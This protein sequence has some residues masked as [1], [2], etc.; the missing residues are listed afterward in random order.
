MPSTQPRPLPNAADKATLKAIAARVISTCPSLNDAARLVANEL[1]RKYAI[2]NHDPDHVYFHRFRSAQSSATSFTGWQHMSETPYESLTLTQLVIHRFRATDVDNADLLDLY[3]GFYS[4]G[5]DAGDFNETNEVR[6]HGHQ[7]LKDFWAIDFSERYRQQLQAFWNECAEDFRTLAKC[8][9]LVQ[10]IEARENRQLSEHDLQTLLD[11]VIGPLTWPVSLPTLRADSAVGAG[12]T[13]RALDIAGHA[14][15]NVLCISAAGGRQI[16]YLPGEADAFVVCASAAELHWWVLQHM[17]R[18]GQRRRLLEHFPLAERQAITAGLSNLMNR[19]VSTWGQSDH[20]LINQHPQMI[21]GDAFAWLRDSTRSA[22]FAEADLS[23]TANSDLRKKLWIGYLSAGLKVFG[24]MAVVGW[25]VALPV[26]GASLANMGLNI[27][28]AVSGRTAAERK[29][30]VIGAILSG[31]DMLF[32]LPFLRGVGSMAE[33]SAEAEAAEWA[34]YADATRTPEESA[35]VVDEPEGTL[36]PPAEHLP[37][38]VDAAPP[39]AIAQ[40]YQ[41][42]EVLDGLTPISAEGKFQGI[43]RLDSEPPYAILLD[44]QAYYVRYFVDSRGGGFWAIVD[45]ARPNQFVHALPVRLNA[46]G[47]WERISRLGLKAGGQC[48]GTQCAPDLELDTFAPEHAEPPPPPAP[49]PAPAPAEQPQLSTARAIGLVQTPYDVEPV[50][51]ALLKNWA[52]RL[53]ETHLHF[54]IGPL[55]DLIAPDR[56]FVHFGAKC[57]ALV[58]SA[59]RFYRNLRWDTLPPRPGIPTVDAATTIDEFIIDA[60]DLAPGLVI[61]QTPGRITS[62]RLMIEHMATFARGGVRTL[63]VNR[64]LND[65]AQL[66][67]NQYFRTGSLSRD[68]ERYLTRMGTDPLERFNELEL[69]KA[70]RHHGIRVQ[71][72]DCAAFYRRPAAMPRPEQQAVT[73]HLTSDIMLLDRSLNDPG[74]WVVL[75]ETPNTNT[76][77]GFAGLSELEGGIGLRVTEVDP[78]QGERLSLDP[79]IVIPRGPLAN[80]GQMSG[81]LETFYADLRLQMEAAPVVRNPQQMSR[82]L[83]RSGMFAFEHS[84]QGYALLH[85]SQAEQ[86]VRTAVQRLGSGYFFIERPA[87]QRV[88]LKAYATLELL[89]QALSQE[90]G[91]MLQS[92]IHD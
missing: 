74:K 61:A 59:K 57:R 66:D 49:E 78:G 23:L 12:Y 35:Y 6:L 91:L 88:H 60:L 71:A 92:R 70:A 8:N 32:D 22:M 10:A 20:Q 2:G 65:F 14:T 15:S 27:D 45:P 25:P 16:L 50:N 90:Y 62:M 58:N 54:E 34:Q 18:P 9:F 86:I 75:T 3:G 26:I 19:L 81:V 29:E 38:P 40:T 36:P 72:T 55:G 85:R 51:R 41:C 48:L 43:Y 28:Q 47:A 46:E 11:A 64:L 56:H 37:V 87:W 31:I 89:A 84:E 53:P 67:L 1:L 69:V 17:N 76:F 83:Y 73:S 77:R 7:V 68:L 44:D 42:N 82:L 30:G 33:I 39:A 79:G 13:V 4:A 80:A 21:S 52:M 5:P 63:Y 24:P